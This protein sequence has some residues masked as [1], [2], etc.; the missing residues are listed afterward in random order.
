MIVVVKPESTSV[1]AVGAAFGNYV[2]HRTGRAAVLRSEL[3]CDDT[4]F[5]NDVRIVHRL[6]HA[7]GAGSVG[8]LPV[9]DEC[10]GSCTHSVGGKLQAAAFSPLIAAAAKLAVAVRYL[11]DTGD[12]ARQI[13]QV[14]VRR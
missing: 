4:D 11:T 8:I 10:V 7:A 14:P 9:D 13:Q 12:R 2:H 1:K 6:H 5:G 3:I